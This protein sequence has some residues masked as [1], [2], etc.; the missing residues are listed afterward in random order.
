MSEEMVF[1]KALQA[2]KLSGTQLPILISVLETKQKSH[3]ITTLKDMTIKMV[4]THRHRPG[5]SEVFNATDN[6]SQNLT[7]TLDG[8][9]APEH[10]E[11]EEWYEGDDDEETF[12]RT[13]EHGEVFLFRPKRAA[14]ARNAPGAAA[15]ATQGAI[16]QFRAIPNGRPKGKGKGAMSCLRCGQPGHFRRQC[17]QPFRPNLTSGPSGGKSSG[18]KGNQKGKSKGKGKSTLTVGETNEQGDYDTPIEETPTTEPNESGN[19]PAEENGISYDPTADYQDPWLAYYSAYATPEAWITMFTR[20]CATEETFLLSNENIYTSSAKYQNSNGT[21]AVINNAKSLPPILIDSGASG[22][23]VGLKWVQQWGDTAKQTFGK[24]S[25]SFRFGDGNERPS[26]GTCVIPIILR[27]GHT[28]QSKDVALNI[29]ADVVHAD[30]PLLLS[31]RSLVALNGQLDFSRSTLTIEKYIIIRTRQLTLWALESSWH[32][33]GKEQ[34]RWNGSYRR[35]NVAGAHKLYPVLQDHGLIPMTDAEIEKV[36]LH[37][38]RCSAFTLKSLLKEGHRVVDDPQIQRVLAGCT[39][40]GA[41]NRITP[42]KLTGWSSKFRGEIIGIDAAYPFVGTRQGKNGRLLPTLLIV[43]CLS[44]FS[45]CAMLANVRAE[46]VTGV[47]LNDW[48]RPLGK[49]RR[50]IADQGSPGMT[51]VEWDD[52]S[53]TYCIQLVYAPSQA[54]Q[55]NG[56][57]ERVARSLK[58]ALRQL[59]LDPALQPSQA[60]LT[61]VTMDRNHVPN[62]VTGIT[63]ALAMTGRSDILAGHASTAWNHDP[64]SIDPA[65]RQ[66]NAMRNILNARSALIQADANRALATC[67]NR[68]LP[69]RSHEFCPVGSSVQ[70]AL[71]GERVGTFRVLGRSS[72]NLIV[73]RGQKVMKW[74]K[75]K[76][77]LI[78]AQREDKLEQAPDPPVDGEESEV[79]PTKT[80]ER[81]HFRVRHR[82]KRAPTSKH[83][84]AQS[85]KDDPITQDEEEADALDGGTQEV[86]SDGEAHGE[87][88]VA[89]RNLSPLHPGRM[90]PTGTF[91][92]KAL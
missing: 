23:A 33:H 62:T 27:P 10:P 80:A 46:T 66:S 91:E 12:E 56:L 57:V 1:A 92:I 8:W 75:Y 14:K 67:A 78:L 51:R 43:D 55:Q 88:L 53:H 79:G 4:E 58:F 86:V 25:R 42:P 44:R 61:Q 84:P 65:V 21:P 35:N 89:Q 28:N 39:C 22:A 20:S 40:R 45:I 34:V 19:N 26:I 32:S 85:S 48:I 68:N 83:D 60:L 90:F 71:R 11:T 69:D 47:L 18:K 81:R 31:K 76:T 54:P 6:Q 24:S 29:V 70:I 36:H 7:D 64:E 15:S 77:R 13:D 5:P 82:T 3:C 63:P 49:P 2:L 72:S 59:L 16:Q 37:L 38:S 52:L 50:I 87:F 73:E 30:V 41:V 17:P 9:E 74:P